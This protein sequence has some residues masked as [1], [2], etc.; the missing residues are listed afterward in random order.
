MPTL[1]DK[2]KSLGVKIGAQNLPPPQSRNSYSIEK[3]VPGAPLETPQ[4]ETYVVETRYPVDYHH[5]RLALRVSASL[6]VIADWAREPHILEIP[7][8][9]FGFLDIETTGLSGGTGTYAFLIGI[10]RFEGDEF[11]LA[12]FF[13]RDPIEEPAQ[14]FALEEFLAP[15]QALVTFNGKAFDAPLLNTRFTAHGWRTP[16]SGLA[17]LDLLHLARR[18]WRD[19]LPSRTLGNLEVQ[20]LGANRIEEDVPGWMIPSLYM[21]YLRDGDARPLKNVFYHNAMDV[22]SLAALFNHMAELLANPFDRAAEHG[23]DLISM[24]RLFED[25][26]DL[27]SATR[28]YVHALNHPDAVEQRL[29]E[30]ILLD[31]IQRLA[32]IHKRQENLPAAVAL[33]EQ[34]ARHQFL[35][36]HIELAKFYEHRLSNYQEAIQWTQSAM[37]VVQTPGFPAYERRQWLPELEHRL[38]RLQRKLTKASP[39]ED[40]II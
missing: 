40:D 23:V 36:A 11:H 13:M 32:M 22:V 38:A 1:S 16:L 4:G 14:L 2:L 29:P 8:Q 35:D 5:G 9:A 33:W 18:L 27:D 19:R 21:D 28:L 20:I 34:A 10:G 24:A 39:G 7:Q 3:V 17:H 31:A 37:A 26:Q 12:Q 6:Q 25:L 30:Q 15:C